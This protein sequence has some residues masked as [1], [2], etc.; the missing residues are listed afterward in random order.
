MKLKSFNNNI[1]T[2]QKHNMINDNTGICISNILSNVNTDI[3]NV[4]ADINNINADINNITNDRIIESNYNRIDVLPTT[5]TNA[6]EINEEFIATHENNIV[7]IFRFKFTEEFMK[8]LHNFSKIHQYDHRK[9][10]KTA[11]DIW[12]EENDN[13]VKEETARLYSLGYEGD[14][15]DK[16]FKSARYYFRKKSSEKK[17]PKSRKVYVGVQKG[18][19]DAMDEHITNGIKDREYKPSEGFLDFCKANPELLK[20]EIVRLNDNGIVD[21]DG[22][23]NKIKKTYKNRYF[24]INK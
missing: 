1:Q 14:I 22:I 15:L 19:L 5:Y 9:D 11:W 16:M 24:M 17:T 12:V 3:N 2:K 21:T 4:N 8:E 18:L 7:S 10:F 20:E 6:C 13:L 23:K